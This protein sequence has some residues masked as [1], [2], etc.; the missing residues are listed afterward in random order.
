MTSDDVIFSARTFWWDV[1]AILRWFVAPFQ[2]VREAAAVPVDASRRRK[3]FAVLKVK[4]DDMY[5]LCIMRT[6]S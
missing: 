4:I 1:I 3:A 5:A 2:D 6:S